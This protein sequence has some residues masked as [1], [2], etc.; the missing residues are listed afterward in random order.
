[1]TRVHAKVAA[2]ITALAVLFVFGVAHADVITGGE[3]KVS[4]SGSMSPQTLPR[5]GTR[6]IALSVQASVNPIGNGRPPALRRFVVAVN[7]HAR[8]S[9]RGLPVC[10]WGSVHAL[11]TAQAL[12]RCRGALV[13][14]GHFTAHIYLPEES[15][16]PSVGRALVFNSRLHGRPALLLHIYGAKPAPTVEVLPLVIGH[17]ERGTST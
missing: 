12:S 13:G 6:P 2:L 16:F 15:P 5:A 3:F 8:L 1:M 7:R 9:T 10:H 14:T 4:F 11:K 17:G